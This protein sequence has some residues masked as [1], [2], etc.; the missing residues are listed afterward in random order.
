MLELPT[1]TFIIP[2]RSVL[3][4]EVLTLYFSTLAPACSVTTLKETSHILR[5]LVDVFGILTPMSTLSGLR[6]STLGLSLRRAN[7]VKCAQAGRQAGM[8]GAGGGQGMSAWYDCRRDD[9][10][11]SHPSL[12]EVGKMKHILE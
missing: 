11:P 1:L 2:G 3:H 7:L 6:P 4:L 9:G 10:T 12:R 5:A 8:I